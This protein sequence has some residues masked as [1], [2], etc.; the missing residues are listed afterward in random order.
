MN[1]ETS[2]HRFGK[3]ENTQ[4]Q[5]VGS[6]LREEDLRISIAAET[7]QSL[8][9]G[10]VNRQ[11]SKERQRYSDRYKTQKSGYCVSEGTEERKKYE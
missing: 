8:E 1:R 5:R 2:V 10:W 9:L 3:I 7:T 11:Q 4:P 6:A